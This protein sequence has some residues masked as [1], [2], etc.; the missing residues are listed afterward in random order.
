MIVQA[1]LDATLNL[2]DSGAREAEIQARRAR[3]RGA[4][5]RYLRDWLAAVRETDDL[6]AELRSQRQRRERVAQRLRIGERLYRATL[7]RYREGVSDY[8]P[9]LDALR[10]LQQQQREALHL[11]AGEQRILVQL[12]IAIGPPAAPAPQGGRP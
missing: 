2:F 12:R 3:L 7:D 6:L 8:L 5:I 9:L 11:R 1:A 10:G 4:G